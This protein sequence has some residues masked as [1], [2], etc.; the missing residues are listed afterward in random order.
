[1]KISALVV[2]AV[3]VGALTGKEWDPIT[4]DGDMWD[5]PIEAENVEPSDA[6][7]FISPKEA[8]APLSVGDILPSPPDIFPFPPL[9][10]EIIH[11]LSGMQEVTFC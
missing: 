11:S 7:G 5:D 8:V 3:K 9:A 2:L 4:R 6:Q 10:E 1:M